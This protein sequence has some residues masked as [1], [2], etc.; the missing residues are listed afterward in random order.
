M[1]ETQKTEIVKIFEEITE[2]KLA[3]FFGS[4]AL[5]NDGPLSDYDFAVFLDEKNKEK[6]FKIKAVILDKLGRYLRSDNIDLVVLD[7]AESPELKYN[8]IKDG[9]VIYEKEPFRI[10]LEPLILNEYFDFR[11]TLIRNNLSK[12]YD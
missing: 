1:N 10:I 11:E 4:R 8:I 7:S 6:I 9:V 5:G 12:R 3:Y 2:V